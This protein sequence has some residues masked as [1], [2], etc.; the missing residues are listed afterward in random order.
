MEGILFFVEF[1]PAIDSIFSSTSN[2]GSLGE[3]KIVGVADGCIVA[4]E[5]EERNISDPSSSNQSGLI[6]GNKRKIF[7]TK[8]KLG[9]LRPERICEIADG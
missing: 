8:S 5:A 4:E 2:S 6:S 1:S 7:T 9:L 3:E